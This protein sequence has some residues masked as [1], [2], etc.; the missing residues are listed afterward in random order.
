M[1]NSSRRVLAAIALLLACAARS[2]AQDLTGCC[3]TDQMMFCINNVPPNMCDGRFI[4]GGVCTAS[5]RGTCVSSPI[6]APGSSAPAPAAS[7]GT[8]AL[9]AVGL[10]GTGALVMQRRTH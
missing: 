7:H 3:Q 4:L 1:R 6:S 10:L 9:M 2:P 5:P 8:L